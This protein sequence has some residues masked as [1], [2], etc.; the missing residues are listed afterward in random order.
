MAVIEAIA[1]TY[2]EA[3]ATSVTFSS[4]GSYE[5]LQLRIS[6]KSDYTGASSDQIE[7]NFNGDTTA[8]YAYHLIICSETVT[9]AVATAGASFIKV[10][11]IS[12]SAANSGTDNYG[13]M[14]VDILDYKDDGNKN[15][16]VAGTTGINRITTPLWG[17]SQSAFF[18]G[19]WDVQDD[20]TSIVLT[21]SGG[22]NFIRGSEFSLFG[23]ASS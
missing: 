4:L 7:L 20:V 13:A 6:A 16:T 17:G 21:P 5:H 15:T 12:S 14:I 10:S 3:N 19:L 22:S 8:N 23:L 1:T 2:L 9:S 11:S 18:S